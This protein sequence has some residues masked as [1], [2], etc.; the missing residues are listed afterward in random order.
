M[1]Q[2]IHSGNTWAYVY[3]QSDAGGGDIN[4]ELLELQIRNSTLSSQAK[5][6]FINVDYYNSDTYSAAYFDD[7]VMSTGL[8]SSDEA[9]LNAVVAAHSGIP[10][11]GLCVS[12]EL[13]GTAEVGATS[14]TS[15]LTLSCPLLLS[16]TWLIEASGELLLKSAPL[17]SST[18]PNAFLEGKIQWRPYPTSNFSDVNLFLHYFNKWDTRA[19]VQEVQLPV[20]ST[21]EIV[22]QI[23]TT[24]TAIKVQARRWRVSLSPMA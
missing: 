11:S 12:T 19:I 23:R 4:N 6:A 5:S 1:P 24:T 21:P 7:R 22:V 2:I 8:S 10:S 20:A 14:Y 3:S 13:A 9:I 17:W 15:V 16:G 18:G